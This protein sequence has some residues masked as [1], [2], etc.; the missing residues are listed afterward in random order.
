M[1]ISTPVQIGAA[2]SGAS[3][4]TLVITTTT[5][6][7]AGAAIILGIGFVNVATTVTS[8]T[9]SAG[10]T[11]TVGTLASG[12]NTRGYFAF[13]ANTLALASSGTITITFAVAVTLKGAGAVSVVGLSSAPADTEGAGA[14]GTSTAPTITSA[15]LGQRDEIVFGLVVVNNGFADTFTEASGFSSDT[16]ALVSGIAV[17]SGYQIVSATTAVTYAPT[18]GTS[19]TWVAQIKSFKAAVYPFNPSNKLTFLEM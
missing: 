19:R 5:A 12:S 10:N 13:S 15:T 9:D 4:T 6:S 11:Y 18:L 16:A 3:T 2:A 7:P 17:R 14:T 1:T 8:V